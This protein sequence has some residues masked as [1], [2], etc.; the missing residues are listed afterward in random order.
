[1]GSSIEETVQIIGL[2][3]YTNIIVF[4]YLPVDQR[5]Q[6][7]RVLLKDRSIFFYALEYDCGDGKDQSRRVVPR[8]GQDMVNQIPM[9]PS[10]AIF[11]RMHVYESKREAGCGD[12]RVQLSMHLSVEIYETVHQALKVVLPCTYV[13]GNRHTGITVMLAYK[14]AVIAKSNLHEAFVAD[15]NLLQ[16]NQFRQINWCPPR[17]ADHFSPA[18]NSTLRRGF[19]F[20]AIA[21]PRILQQEECR[22]PRNYITRYSTYKRTSLLS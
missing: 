17:L 2:V 20:D 16:A 1:M 7:V 19:S 8:L 6:L 5:Q 9:N 11:E 18:L 14:A 13:L 12:H 22:R 3:F 4:T 15:N 21:R 10:V